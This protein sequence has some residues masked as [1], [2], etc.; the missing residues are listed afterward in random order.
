MS[1][2]AS[3]K[4]KGDPLVEVVV[5]AEERNVP[6]DLLVDLE[7]EERAALDVE[8]HRLRP[9]GREVVVGVAARGGGYEMSA[10]RRRESA[11]GKRLRQAR[12]WST[13]CP[14]CKRENRK[15]NQ[16]TSAP[17]R[18]QRRQHADAPLLTVA[19]DPTHARV[20]A[21][22]DRDVLALERHVGLAVRG[23]PGK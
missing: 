1:V 7:I 12:T 11:G 10:G 13:R 5:L 15:K 16:G 9:V 20:L 4:T 23:K 2:A 6:G 3:T 17:R 14:T 18:R 21:A 8:R 19:A 22:L